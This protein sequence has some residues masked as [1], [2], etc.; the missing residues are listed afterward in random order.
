MIARIWHGRIKT[1]Q[2]NEYTEYVRK[3]GV[4]RHRQT[5]GNRGS[6]IL[7]RT[8]DSVTH[9]LVVSFWES[10][11]AIKAFAGGAPEVA[12]YF[13]EDERYLLEL[14]PGVQ[15]YEVPVKELE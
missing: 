14:E 9:I 6:M 4:A 10:L 5:P 1:E 15:H 7:T 13:P 8:E 11:E 12:V 2:T 3:T